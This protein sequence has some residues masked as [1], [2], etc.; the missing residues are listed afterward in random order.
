VLVNYYRGRLPVY[1]IDAYRT[2]T[3]TEILDLG[4]DE[5]VASRG[6]TVVE[7]ADKLAP[8]LPP[9]SIWVSISGLGDEPRE[10][11]IESPAG[12]I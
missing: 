3:L 10:I 2:E 5:F 9:D 7:W 4:F 12:R 11:R 1:H 8:L 6:V